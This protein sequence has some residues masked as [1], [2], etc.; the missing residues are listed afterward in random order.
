MFRRTA[1][2]LGHETD[3]ENLFSQ[4]KHRTDPNMKPSFLR[5][6]TKTSANRHKYNPSVQAVWDRYQSKFKGC[7]TYPS[8]ES[9]A[10]SSDPNSD[11]E[12]DD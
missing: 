6:L 5:V 2:H 7:A 10:E 9:S 11:S 8:D 1:C 3:S 4:T 12:S